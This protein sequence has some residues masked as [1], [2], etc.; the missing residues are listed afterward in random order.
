MK[1]KSYDTAQGYRR[2]DPGSWRRIWA[3]TMGQKLT[4]HLTNRGV[5]TA[6]ERIKEWMLRT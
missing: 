4:P 6:R 1:R 5:G 2:R 3:T